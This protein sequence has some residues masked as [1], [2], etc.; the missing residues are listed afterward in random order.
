[1]RAAGVAVAA[2]A[3]VVLGGCASYAI[4]TNADATLVTAT[5]KP[6]IVHLVLISGTLGIV[7][8]GCFGLVGVDGGEHAAVFPF[9]TTAE[10]DA[11]DIP[12]LGVV[13]VGEPIEGGGHFGEAV[14]LP[15]DFP[16]ECRTDGVAY[17]NPFD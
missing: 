6:G 17:L 13:T 10:D 14:E 1:M 12:G 16:Q 9:G 15:A 3:V 11:L 7:G 5:S 4:D 2:A 8:D